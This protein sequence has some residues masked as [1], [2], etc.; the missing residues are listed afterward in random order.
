MIN[1]VHMLNLV[2]AKAFENEATKRLKRSNRPGTTGYYQSIQ[3][4]KEA[5]AR[6]SA[7]YALRDYAE[8]NSSYYHMVNVNKALLREV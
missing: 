5:W 7:M 2:I 4:E 8:G 6:Q 3:I 1:F